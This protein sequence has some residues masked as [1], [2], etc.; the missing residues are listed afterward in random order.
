M[1]KPKVLI[2][3]DEPNNLQLL[4]LML[5]ELDYNLSFANNGLRALQLAEENSPDLVLLDI[6]MPEVD[7]WEVLTQ[8]KDH[9]QLSEIPVILQTALQSKEDFNRGLSLGAYYYVTK[10]IDR[11]L[12]VPLVKTALEEQMRI[13][14]LKQELEKTDAILSLTEEWKLNFRTLEQA[15]SIAKLV[16]KTCPDPNRSL[17]GLLEIVIN[18]VEHGIAGISYD[19]KTELKINNNWNE[20]VQQRIDLQENKDK[21]VTLSM[22][23]ENSKITIQVKDPGPGF[24]WKDYL[25]FSIERAT[26][27]HGRGIAMAKAMSFDALEYSKVGN[28]VTMTIH[29]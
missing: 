1:D 14:L 8:M 6:M 23:R 28:E 12:L 16:S 11:D 15:Y 21:Y 4:K 19:E 3:D 9:P 27:N 20:V 13:R 22:K 17:Q 2:V 10:P 7:G 26:D 18:A 5:H 24:N 25:E 29:L